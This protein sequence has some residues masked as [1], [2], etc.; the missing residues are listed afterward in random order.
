MEGIVKKPQFKVMRAVF[1][2]CIK[3]NHSKALFT[4][5]LFTIIETLLSAVPL[6]VAMGTSPNGTASSAVFNSPVL[7]AAASFVLSL[8]F[9]IVLFMM[10]YG[11]FCVTARMVQKK[12]VTVGWLF[13]AFRKKDRRVLGSSIVFTVFYLLLGFLTSFLFSLVIKKTGS[14]LGISGGDS[15][16]VMYFFAVAAIVFLLAFI[17]FSFVHLI[18]YYFKNVRTLASFAL[19][20]RILRGQMLHFM[21]FV[22]NAA[23]TSLLSV[24]LLTVVLAFIPKNLGTSVGIL[25]MF[26]SIMR[27]FEYY[28]VMARV[29]IAIPVYFFFTVGAVQVVVSPEQVPVQAEDEGS[30]EEKDSPTQ[31]NE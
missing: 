1:D 3:L 9:C 15:S 23:G 8:A 2:Q 25:A 16:S 28:K 7:K 10:L 29:L 6:S 24:I 18:L 22:I 17:P 21:A 26:L 12:S 27:L 5:F 19:S 4:V 20:I 30:A 31:E 11:M 13:I 14:F